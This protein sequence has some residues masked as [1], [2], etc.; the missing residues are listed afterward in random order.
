[1]SSEEITNQ[2]Y[3]RIA[4]SFA[5]RFWNI[6]LEHALDGF[7][8]LVKARRRVLDLGC[9]P[10]RDIGLLR[11]RGMRVFGLDRSMGMLQEAQRRVG[12]ALSCADM[13]RLPLHTE[14]VDGIWMCA[15]LLHIP[16]AEVPTVIAE[17]RRILRFE[18]VL[19]ISVQQGT[20]EGWSESDG[21]KRFFTYFQLDELLELVVQSKFSLQE[22][23]LEA[24]GHSTWIHLLALRQD[25]ESE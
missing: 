9:G 22:H 11:Q 14:S 3:D 24:G 10:G 25:G 4:E 12:G 5:E 19:Y 23:W 2:T 18:G 20:G 7:S 1:M 13:R 17:A 8:L 16:R 21:G 6:T 15:S